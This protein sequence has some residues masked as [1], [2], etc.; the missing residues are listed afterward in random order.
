MY[1]KRFREQVNQW[2]ANPIGIQYGIWIVSKQW[3]GTGPRIL[4]RCRQM[5][6]KPPGSAGVG[7]PAERAGYVIC[8]N[9][10]ERPAVAIVPMNPWS[11]W[12]P[13]LWG[14]GSFVRSCTMCTFTLNL[15]RGQPNSS[16]QVA[17]YRDPQSTGMCSIGLAHTEER[18]LEN[19]LEFE[20]QLLR[21]VCNFD[22]DT[23][24]TTRASAT[25]QQLMR[26]CG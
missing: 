10:L 24:S 8:D 20:L 16:T 13:R 14:R 25:V 9:R 17:A 11:L 3:A 21:S 4:G 1:S 22:T 12:T 19:C 15:Q 23:Y 6:T 2:P 5:E 18:P 7:P 26:T